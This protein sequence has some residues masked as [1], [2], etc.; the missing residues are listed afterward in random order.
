[1]N[2]KILNTITLVAMI[3]AFELLVI[4]F[5][6]LYWQHLA[7]IHHA[8]FFEA[9][10]WGSVTFHWSDN[11]FAQTPFQDAGWAKIQNSLFDQKLKTLD[12]K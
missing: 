9:S 6:S 7:I 3:L 10:S 4:I 1:M 5:T 11:S 12:I 8:A 2:N